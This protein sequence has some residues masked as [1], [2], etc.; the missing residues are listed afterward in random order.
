MCPLLMR[1]HLIE[2]VGKG[3]GGRGVHVEQHTS[4]MDFNV[5]IYV[6]AHITNY[7]KTFATKN[8]TLICCVASPPFGCDRGHKWNTHFST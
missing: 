1:S 6:D 4:L 2:I 5:D 8:I 7:M 3:G